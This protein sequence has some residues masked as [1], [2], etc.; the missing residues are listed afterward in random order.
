M[1]AEM[2]QTREQAVQTARLDIVKSILPA[3]DSL[4]SAFE[5][6][7]WQVL[8]TPMSTEV[9]RTV[10]AWVDGIRLA[11]IRLLDVLAGHEVKPIPSVGTK[12][13]PHYHIAVATDTNA[14]APEGTIVAE[15]RRGYTTA[16]TVLREAEVVVA[17]E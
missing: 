7:R 17:R 10:E 5:S 6:G 9:R 15:D 16:H 4:D 1:L 3:L 2:K 8:N 13:D 14:Q 12:F 11:R